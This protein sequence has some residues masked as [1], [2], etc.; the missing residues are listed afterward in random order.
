MHPLP[1]RHSYIYRIASFTL[2]LALIST[3]FFIAGALQKQTIAK[4]FSNATVGGCPLFPA[5]NIWN[6]DISTLPV[7]R[8]SANYIA[9]IGPTSHIHADFG[10]GLYGGGTIGIPYTVVSGSQ[11]YVPISFTYAG[12][13]NPGP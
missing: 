11:P 1:A 9:S 3:S 10:A 13:S 4:A 6:R 2:T 12:E 8:N 7:H 5:D